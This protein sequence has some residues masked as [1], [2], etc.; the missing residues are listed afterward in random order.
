MQVILFNSRNGRLILKW[1]GFMAFI[2][3]LYRMWPDA[4]FIWTHREPFEV[5]GSATSVLIRGRKIYGAHITKSKEAEMGSNVASYLLRAVRAGMEARKSIDPQRFC[6]LCF[7]SIMSHPVG[8]VQKVYDQFSFPLSSE[9][10]EKMRY[11]FE[12]SK[13]EK[14]RFGG[15]RY[16]PEDFGF[17]RQTIEDEWD[18]YRSRFLR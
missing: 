10:K 5:L 18:F 16:N 3:L 8:A 14:K 1:A 6:D 17:N 7:T 12:N 2:P 9:V 13:R 4:K 11:W 15:H